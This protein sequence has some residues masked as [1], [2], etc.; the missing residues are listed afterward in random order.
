MFTL[1]LTDARTAIALSE[2]GIT[3]FRPMTAQALQHRA[4]PT[5]RLAQNEPRAPTAA[6]VGSFVFSLS[7]NRDGPEERENAPCGICG[8]FLQVESVT[9]PGQ[10]SVT[11]RPSSTRHY[12]SNARELR[13]VSACGCSDFQKCCFY[14]VPEASPG[15]ARGYNQYNQ[16]G[17]LQ[18]FRA[19]CSSSSNA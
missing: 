3:T 14:G 16:N 18:P 13:A 8:P 10:K 4:N 19:F 5:F 7:N 6:T 12:N 15:T 9:V 1:L 2:R 11:G 17:G